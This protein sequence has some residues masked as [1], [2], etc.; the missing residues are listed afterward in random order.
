MTKKSAA[1]SE[2]TTRKGGVNKTPSQIKRRPKAPSPM[3]LR[4]L[5]DG[6][7]AEHEERNTH[8]TVTGRFA[9]D[10]LE[11]QLGTLVIS[12]GTLLRDAVQKMRPQLDAAIKR[13]IER[14]MIP[15]NATDPA[16]G[17]HWVR[18]SDGKLLIAEVIEE[19]GKYK[20]VRFF[21]NLHIRIPLNVLRIER[22]FF[23][24]QRI[25]TPGE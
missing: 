1:I 7:S 6:V 25:E 19:A 3:T 12:G 10:D 15:Y 17:Y 23:F 8:G 5:A 24:L 4:T 21:G 9:P 20:A 14:I 2:G 13:A 16:L 18:R 22:Q 11:Q